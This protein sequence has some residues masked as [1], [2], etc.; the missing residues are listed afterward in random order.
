MDPALGGCCKHDGG[1]GVRNFRVH[2]SHVFNEYFVCFFALDTKARRVCLYL[3]TFFFFFARSLN[4]DSRAS[5]EYK[6]ER[7]T[8]FGVRVAVLSWPWA[9]PQHKTAA[10]LGSYNGR[11]LNRTSGNKDY[12]VEAACAE[13]EKR[14]RELKIWLWLPRRA[15]PPPTPP[16]ARDFRHE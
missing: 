14:T 11:S 9:R 16:A 12:K 7:V 4:S 3:N 15:Q 1:V 13:K 10:S 2:G 8:P 6:D 5:A